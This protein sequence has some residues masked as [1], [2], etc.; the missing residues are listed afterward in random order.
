LYVNAVAPPALLN[1]IVSPALGTERHIFVINLHTHGLRISLLIV[2]G[3]RRNSRIRPAGSDSF[4]PT[5]TATAGATTILVKQSITQHFDGSA[6]GVTWALAAVVAAV[7]LALYLLMD[8]Y[9]YSR[10]G[11]LERNQ[12]ADIAFGIDGKFNL[13]LISLLV[14]I[15]LVCGS[16]SG[17]G[18]LPIP[19]VEWSLREFRLDGFILLFL[20]ASA[21]LAPIGVCRL[22]G[23]KWRPIR[24]AAE[25]LG[26]ILVTIIPVIVVLCAASD[27][28]LAPFFASALLRAQIA[29]PTPSD[30]SILLRWRDFHE[31]RRTRRQC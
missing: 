11:S 17:Y 2:W 6:P 29:N 22:D 9:Y 31:C 20:V 21:P 10:E 23:F 18:V 16:I 26:G 14:I 3:G 30:I 13:L 4:R 27:K 24:Q 5:T 1:G 28:A 19:P 7:L 12:T 25:L 8:S 15:V